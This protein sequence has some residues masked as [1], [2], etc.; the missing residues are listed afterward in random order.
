MIMSRFWELAVGV[1]LYQ[2][3]ILKPG[4][5][6]GIGPRVRRA[7]SAASLL[8][9]VGGFALARP[10]AFP[11]P[12]AFAPVLGTAGLLALLGDGE[13]ELIRRFLSG[14]AAVFPGRISYSLY[15][16]HWPVIV[17][18]RWTI[19]LESTVSY[20]I[21]GF[22]TSA[23]AIASF[24]FVE[25]PFRYSTMLRRQP[26]LAVVGGGL[27][28][29]ALFWA[30][31]FEVFRHQSGFSMSV[32]KDDAVWRSGGIHVSK[33]ACPLLISETA[34]HGGVLR[35][36]V[37]EC[38]ARG[39]R[40]RLLMIG[41]SH[42]G[43]YMPVLLK[44][45]METGTR[46]IVYEK[47][48][49]SYLSLFRPDH[50][51]SATCQEFTSAMTT[52]ILRQARSGDVLF[53]PSLRL[54][55]FGDQWANFPAEFARKA[56]SDT[57]ATQLRAAAVNEAV[58]RLRPLADKGV[59]VVFEAPKPIFRAPPFRCSDWFNRSNPICEPGFG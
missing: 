23:L 36:V 24:Q 35:R 41:D 43:S 17:L 40:G 5:F 1:V 51:A 49:C 8:L 45:S 2:A 11:Y 59:Q 55:R 29:I 26:P 57:E 30:F 33:G 20:L 50:D 48:G 39:P 18:L 25:S 27:A 22:A 31:S 53:L 9:L 15:L 16:W 12:W 46:V 19:G 6:A 38:S 34:L 13:P 3:M 44:F 32:T 52:E 21:A 14:R 4:F 56:M 10:E 54:A 28:A 42:A 7:G 47:L 37:P 58:D